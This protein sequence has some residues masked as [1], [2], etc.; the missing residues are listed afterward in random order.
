M[1]RVVSEYTVSLMNVVLS[2]RPAYLKRVF[3]FILHNISAE[4][5]KSYN[6]ASDT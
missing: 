5:C 4:R 6:S 1:W 3:S 2:V